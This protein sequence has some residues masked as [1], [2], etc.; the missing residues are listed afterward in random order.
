MY[1]KYPLITKFTHFEDGDY[2]HKLG[3]FISED[4]IG[5][6][7]GD[8]NTKRYVEN[9]PMKFTD[10]SGLI[11]WENVLQRFMNN[12]KNTISTLG[13]F[14]IF[15]IAG[16]FTGGGLP[17]T[18]IQSL[19]TAV[20]TSFSAETAAASAQFARI[21]ASTSSSAIA[22]TG[23]RLALKAIARVTSGVALRVYGALIGGIAVGA[24]LDA[25]LYEYATGEDCEEKGCEAK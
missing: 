6:V 22:Q 13:V 17:W 19:A 16:D 7:S 25:L 2:N 8:L 15:G 3:R 23:R 10:P 24:F 1:L 11:C 5:F 14:D 9:N 18:S 20:G 21:A 12:F 4:P